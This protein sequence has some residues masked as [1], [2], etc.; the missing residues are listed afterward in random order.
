MRVDTAVAAPQAAQEVFDGVLRGRRRRDAVRGPAAEMPLRVILQ[1][2]QARIEV[3]RIAPD[4][5]VQLVH[6]LAFT[7][8]DLQVVAR[9]VEQ[10]AADAQR[11]VA[12][13]RGGQDVLH[14]LLVGRRRGEAD[15][16]QAAELVHRV[17]VRVWPANPARVEP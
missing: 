15:V 5:L 1:T 3:A 7:F 14:R 8:E 2:A 13:V 17:T 11:R 9:V 16:E 4:A 6:R 12:P 10:G